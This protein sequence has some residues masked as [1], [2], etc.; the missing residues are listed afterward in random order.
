[1]NFVWLVFCLEH[2]LCVLGMFGPA[3]LHHLHSDDGAAEIEGRLQRDVQ[4]YITFQKYDDFLIVF[5]LSAL[6]EWY[7]VSWWWWAPLPGG[8]LL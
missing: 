2:P 1:M 7:P 8:L 5:F 4:K 6:K 3:R